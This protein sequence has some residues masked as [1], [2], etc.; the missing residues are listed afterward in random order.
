MKFWRLAWPWALRR[1]SWRVFVGGFYFGVGYSSGGVVGEDL[2]GP[3]EYGLDC[4]AVLGN[5]AGFVEGGEPGQG[6]VGSF[7]VGGL[8]D[9]VEFLEGLPPGFQLRV[10]VEQGP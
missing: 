8:V 9:V 2:V 5:V 6:L 10:L 1:S 4:F 3:A 7:Q